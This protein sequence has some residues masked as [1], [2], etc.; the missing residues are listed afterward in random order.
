MGTV[1]Y[2]VI[3][4][5]AV[6][7]TLAALLAEQG[8][9]VLVL[10]RGEHAAVLRAD[11]IE[12]ALPTRTVRVPLEVA[13]SVA[14]LELHPGDVLLLCTKGQHSADL[15]ADLAARPVGAT[16]AGASLPVAC[17]QNGV[18]NERTALRR[19]A[20]VL[21]AC[22]VLP[23]THLEPG[24]VSAEG[25]PL[26]GL[27]ELGR[28]PG[29]V[30]DLVE[31]VAADLTAVGVTTTPREDVMAWKRAKLLRNLGNAVDALS[32][33]ELDE[34]AR[35]L[36]AMARAEGVACFAAAGLSVVDD[37]A[38][39][40]HRG[41]RVQPLSVAGRARAGSSS[42]QSLARGTGSIEAD[43]LNGEVVLLGRLHGVPTPVNALLQHEANRAAVAG[44]AP[45]SV[46]AASLLE[47]VRV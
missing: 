37:D 41:A 33:R 6:G 10:A 43:L 3:G 7:G 25:G 5:G 23:A 30:D 31:Q 21:G 9:P 13:E 28:Y 29:G 11:G 14:A 17:V 32:G 27:F 4:A 36:E 38:W 22:V 34:A 44:R 39:A 15:L 19:F 47:R 42:W 18:E 8:R 16:T 45:G 35:E 1:R 2:V 26:T 12:L 20:T 24:R 46:S 40:D